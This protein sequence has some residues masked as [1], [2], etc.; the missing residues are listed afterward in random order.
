MLNNL[1]VKK[2]LN[3]TSIALFCTTFL[4]HPVLSMEDEDYIVTYN[5]SQ[6]NEEDSEE[7]QPSQS[8]LGMSENF[9]FDPFNSN[10]VI[11][12]KRENDGET[13][14]VFQ[15]VYQDNFTKTI[16]GFLMYAQASHL[17]TTQKSEDT[18]LAMALLKKAHEYGNQNA[19]LFLAE[20]LIENGELS[21]AKNLLNPFI[22]YNEKVQCSLK[23]MPESL[24][25]K[26]TEEV[27]EK[28]KNELEKKELLSY[29]NKLKILEEHTINKPQK[30]LPKKHKFS[31]S[32]QNPREL[33]NKLEEELPL[34][35]TKKI[36]H[37]D[38]REKYKN[39]TNEFKITK[40]LPTLTINDETPKEMSLPILK[41]N[42][43]TKSLPILKIDNV[44]ITTHSLPIITLDRVGEIPHS[45]TTLNKDTL[46]SLENASNQRN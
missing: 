18:T 9:V 45:L 36:L 31:I 27:E 26:K 32:L 8:I 23:K 35:T 12:E 2:T 28:L 46:E 19:T 20:K 14:P 13:Q 11:I 40:S 3:A 6:S 41:K 1:F 25:K 29:V 42:K 24:N 5:I 4:S 38:F 22:D 33:L 10:K 7:T 15:S 34:T 21:E 39:L 44:I 37:K 43:T 30:Q 17:F 16:D